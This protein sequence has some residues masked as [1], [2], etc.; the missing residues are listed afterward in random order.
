MKATTFSQYFIFFLFIF[1]ACS[2]EKKKQ[3]IQEAVKIPE[4]ELL[5]NA[6]GFYDRGLYKLSQENFSR[7]KD[8]FGSSPIASF[9]ELKMAD[10][11]FY[12]GDFA[13]A[14]SGYEE[15]IRLH[16]GHEALSY[17]QFQVAES[18]LSQYQGTDHDQ[19]PLKTAAK[20]FLEHSKRN[21]QTLY[22]KLAA[23]RYFQTREFLAEYE[24]MIA[25]FYQRRGD[26]SAANERIRIIQS[27]FNKTEVSNDDSLYIPKA[28]DIPSNPVIIGV[29]R[30]VDE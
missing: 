21:P 27:E 30:K 28:Q 23:F 14:I 16:P 10:A 26:I 25:K 5:E 18:Y 1:C 17:A 13:T 22:T 12:A 11:A 19:A 2:T 20:L 6:K 9:A 7:L 24:R 15:F 3:Q 8:S 4:A 29:E